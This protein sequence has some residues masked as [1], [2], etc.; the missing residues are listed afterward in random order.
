MLYFV[1]SHTLIPVPKKI[2]C[3]MSGDRVC[4]APFVYSAVSAVI[5]A[6]GCQTFSEMKLMVSIQ[7]TRSFS[8]ISVLVEA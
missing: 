1:N 8:N 5:F 2:F 7:I 4:T 6:V 3:I